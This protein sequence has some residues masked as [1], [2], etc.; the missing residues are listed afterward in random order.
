MLPTFA[1]LAGVDAPAE[2]DG[3]SLVPT[4][5]GKPHQQKQHAFLYWEFKEKQAV[6]MGDWKAVRIGGENSAL[7]LYNLKNDI[8]ET[9]DVSQR[10]PETLAKIK[11]IMNN[12]H[13]L[14]RNG[15]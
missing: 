5:L 9:Q 6:R 13:H 11:A 4:L 10:H 7:E 8:G 3:L 2:I 1:E 15:S 14:P 12:S